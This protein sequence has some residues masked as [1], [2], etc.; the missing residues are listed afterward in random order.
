MGVGVKGT[1]ELAESVTVIQSAAKCHVQELNFDTIKLNGQNLNLEETTNQAVWKI[2]NLKATENS[3]LTWTAS[4]TTTSS[5]LV[6]GAGEYWDHRDKF[7]PL[8][9]AG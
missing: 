3:T 6:P 1:L 4:H 8:D 9:F 7:L 2:N 5:Y